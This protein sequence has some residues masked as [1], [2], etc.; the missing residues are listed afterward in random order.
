VIPHR[1]TIVA[2][3]NPGH[4]LV[5]AHYQ[6]FLDDREI[7]PSDVTIRLRA[8][9]VI[10]VE[11]ELPVTVVT[12]FSG[13][14]TV[15]IDPETEDTL[16]GLGWTPPAPDL[17]AEHPARRFMHRTVTFDT[18]DDLGRGMLGDDDDDNDPGSSRD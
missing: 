15:V 6:I 18:T 12:S 1:I 7:H 16:L 11:L 17:P 3:E 5:A 10:V 8:T 9:D 13:E 4:Q 14:A 2:P